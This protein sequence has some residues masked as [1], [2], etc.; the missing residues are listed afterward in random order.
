MFYSVS[1]GVFLIHFYASLVAFVVSFTD[2]LSIETFF[3]IQKWPSLKKIEQIYSKVSQ[4]DRLQWPILSNIFYQNLFPYCL[5]V[6]SREIS[7]LMQL[8]T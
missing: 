2:S 4:L 6:V 7:F 8:F 3:V 5:Y 1:P